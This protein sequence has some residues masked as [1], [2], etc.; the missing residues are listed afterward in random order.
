MKPDQDVC[1]CYGVTL[2]KLVNFIRRERPEVA[3]RI[4]E[5]LSAGTGCG[6]CVPFLEKLHRDALAG[7]Y[8]GMDELNHEEYAR[9]REEWLAGRMPRPGDEGRVSHDA[10]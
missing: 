9:M 4:S 5:C 2:R 1:I 10:S 6:W 8:D 3:S 7:K